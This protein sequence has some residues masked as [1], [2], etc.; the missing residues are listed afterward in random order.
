[1]WLHYDNGVPTPSPRSYSLRYLK[2]SV[3]SRPAER[4]SQT[5]S[6]RYAQLNPANRCPGHSKDIPGN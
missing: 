5:D 4:D 3:T 2:L 1:M 6:E